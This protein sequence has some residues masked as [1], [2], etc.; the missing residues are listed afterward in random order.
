PRTRNKRT[1]EARA[2]SKEGVLIT[3]C[4]FYGRLVRVLLWVSETSFPSIAPVV[5][6]SNWNVELLTGCRVF[7]CT[8]ETSLPSTFLLEFTSP[9]RTSMRAETLPK[10]LAESVTPLS[11]TVKCEALGTPV[12]LTKY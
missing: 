10:L 11:V 4:N 3:A 1:P 12:R 5:F 8:A 9:N 6:T 7:A 2:L